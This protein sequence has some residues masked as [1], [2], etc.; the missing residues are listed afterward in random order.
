MPRHVRLEPRI[1]VGE[2]KDTRTAG[3]VAL[4]AI[5]ISFVRT[6]AP[7]GGR[8]VSRNGNV[9]DVIDIAY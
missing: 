7:I 1:A 6:R 2:L 9:P 8:D 4:Q 5:P 3:I